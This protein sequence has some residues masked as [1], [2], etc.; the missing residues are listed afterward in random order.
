[1]TTKKSTFT[2]LATLTTLVG[3][4]ALMATASLLL[5]SQ[6]QAKPL[7]YPA[8]TITP[9]DIYSSPA[10]TP[11]TKNKL[12]ERVTPAQRVIPVQRE[13]QGTI[14]S[15]EI[16]SN[17]APCD[18]VNI[19]I[20]GYLNNKPESLAKG[21]ATGENLNRGC[22]YKITYPDFQDSPYSYFNI[23]LDGSYVGTKKWVGGENFPKIPSQYNF[24]M[25]L[26]ETLK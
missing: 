17:L 15:R 5:A 14:G 3:L 9:S 23:N 20:T 8:Q 26:V 1:M 13:V 11:G 18:R 25:K 7:I 10:I 4:S 19:A 22:N 12:D 16:G 24:Y 6:V 21:I 2:V